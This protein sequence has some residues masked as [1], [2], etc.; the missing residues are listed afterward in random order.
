[1]QSDSIPLINVYFTLCTSFSLFS[2]IWFSIVNHLRERKQLPI[3]LRY[4]ILKYVE[5][6]SITSC[7]KNKNKKDETHISSKYCFNFKLN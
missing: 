4:L 1:V 5:F 7:S 6:I 3:C 2:M